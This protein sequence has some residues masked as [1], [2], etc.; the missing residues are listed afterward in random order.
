M[1]AAVAVANSL[2]AID[3]GAIHVQGT[4]NGMANGRQC[5]ICSIIPDLQ[6]MRRN[7]VSAESL[8]HLTDP[9]AHYV[10]EIANLPHDTHAPYVGDS[11]FAHKGGIHVAAMR[12]NVLS[13]QHIAQPR[14]KTSSAPLYQ[15]SRA[16]MC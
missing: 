13:C 10:A 4:I 6:K 15:V 14:S 5:R 3:V 11:A 16:V 12:R 1:T 7:C 8:T 2:A 9:P